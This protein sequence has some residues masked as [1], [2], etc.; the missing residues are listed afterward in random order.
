MQPMAWLKNKVGSN[1]SEP[2]ETNAD[3]RV[4]GDRRSGKT[5][6]MASLAYWPNAKA[7]SPIQSVTSTGAQS[8]SQELL[9]YA[10]DILEQGLELKGTPLNPNIRDVKDYG[11]SILL[12]DQFK[13]SNLRSQSLQ[14]II[15][16]KDYSGE[17]YSDLL[18]KPNDPILYDYLND[19]I[20]ATGILLLVDGTAYAKD[21]DYARSLDAFFSAIN[22]ADLQQEKKRIAFAISKCELSQLWVRR[23]DPKGLV[24]SLFPQ[25][26]GKIEVWQQ[27]GL[28]VINYFTL[29]SFGIL[30]KQYPEPNT[31]LIASDQGGTKSSIRDPKRWRPFGL[32]SPIYWLCTG[33]RHKLLDKD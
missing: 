8:A 18:N 23:H 30:G 6:Y 32:V 2:R 11:L 15:N 17:F 5:V 21:R 7:D 26:M 10:Q 9:K 27:R 16:C 13:F 3:I 33:Q 28:G 29:S 19:C 22:K 14:L 24:S 20:R 31:V 25:M 12:K 4:I 1:A